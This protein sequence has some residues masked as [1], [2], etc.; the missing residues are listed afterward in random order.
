MGIKKKANGSKKLSLKL[1]KNA[2]WKNLISRPLI[3][4]W[5]TGIAFVV[6]SSLIPQASLSDNNSNMGIDKLARLITFGFLGFFPIAFFSSIKF[7]FCVSSSMPALGF[8]LEL[9]QR[10]VPGRHFSP[11]DI[12]ANNIGA[13]LGIIV[14]IIIRT[15]FHTGR[16]TKKEAI[17]TKE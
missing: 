4:L 11:E 10:Y 13:V 1:N 9:M 12:I 5:I 3:V 15:L 8:L 6:V 16:L 2:L 14:A 7:G 17:P